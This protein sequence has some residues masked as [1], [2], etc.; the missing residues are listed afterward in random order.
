MRKKCLI[1]SL[2]LVFS[3]SGLLGTSAMSFKSEKGII[4]VNS[5]ANMEV[6]PDVAE[7]SFAVQTSHKDS[8]QIASVENKKISDEV[9]SML[10]TFINEENGDFIKTSDFKANPIYSYQNSKKIFE[11]YEV[12]NKVIIHTKSI[13]KIGLMIDN[14]LK[15]GATNVENL[16]FAVS[17]YESQCNELISEASQKA[18]TRASL[19]AK[20]LSSSI[21]GISNITTSCGI[22]EYNTPRLY[23]AKNM[24][25]DVAAGAT[26]SGVSI[27][28]GIIKINANVNA[29]FFVK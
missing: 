23:M 6:A 11:R 16:T 4:S 29:T 9:F 18:K 2:L 28:N 19:I 17:D 14:A 21:S 5:S 26:T 24:I 25:S 7:I 1:L 3:M 13:D 12:S 22:N 8:M 20:T 10:K 15:L 27:S